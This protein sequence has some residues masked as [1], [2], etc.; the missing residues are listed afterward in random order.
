LSTKALNGLWHSMRSALISSK[1]CWANESIN[2]RYVCRNPLSAID[3]PSSRLTGGIEL[4]FLSNTILS[5]DG[6]SGELVV[7]CAGAIGTWQ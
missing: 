3:H 2:T 5:N 1:Q 6:D 4:R 7:E